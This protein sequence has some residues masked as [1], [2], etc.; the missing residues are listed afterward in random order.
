M[1]LLAEIK[2]HI[3]SCVSDAII[4]A[5]EKGT[6]PKAEP[7]AFTVEIPKDTSHGDFATN[8]A[9]VGAKVFRMPPPVIA[10]A[11]AENIVLH[12]WIESVEV[13][14]TFINFRTS[15]SF[16]ADAVRTV[17]SEGQAYGDSDFGKNEKVMVEYVSANPTGMMHMGNARGGALGDCLATVMKKTGFDVTREFYVNDAGNQIEKFKDSLSARYLQIFRGEDAVPFPEDGYK[18]EDI[19]DRAR[20][21]ADIHGDKYVDA[22][23]DERR[24]TLL[25]YALPKNLGIIKQNLAQYRCEYDNWFMESDLHR[26][27]AVKNVIDIMTANGHTY[28]KDGAL[29]YRATDFGAE[30]DEVLVRKNGTPTYFAA[31]IA[32]HRNKIVDRGFSRAIDI[33]GA[34]HYGHVA[35]LKGALNAIGVDGNKLE[36]IIMQ[37]V[38]L[39][40]NGETVRMSKR[41]GRSITLE[42]LFEIS[43][44]DAARFFFNMRS[45]DTHFDFDLDLSIAQT[46]QN[47][48]Y[49]VQYAHARIC[50]I[51]SVLAQSGIDVSKEPGEL[52]YTEKE[53]RELIR[54]LMIYPGELE[55]TAVDYDVSRLTKY[56]MDLATA[57]HSFYNACRVKAE[58]EKIMYSRIALVSAAKTVL[59][60]VLGI[61]KVS[62]PEKM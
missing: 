41:T 33:W 42:D 20:E 53:E 22:P 21:F 36:V 56:A 43:S 46:N 55:H 49:Y 27:G 5:Q 60:N 35:R 48:V 57:F 10:K 11:I 32:Y 58:D 61:L 52:V 13:A 44:I 12:K 40:Q 37:L 23:E 24:Q 38:R 25:E 62:A 54:Q 1:N 9:M 28:E 7:Y 14:G 19:K 2:E 50:S 6:L 18:G 45:A 30:K 26:S 17:N 59:E 29:W 16:F 47:P 31:D 39:V 8:A 4:R 34:D 51:L 15:G 3:S